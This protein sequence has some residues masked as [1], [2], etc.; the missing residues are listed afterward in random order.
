MPI[1]G[2]PNGK[3]ES[4][5]IGMAASPGIPVFIGNAMKA[6]VLA[7]QTRESGIDRLFFRAD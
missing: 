1:A 2:I 5:A 7:G 6:V 4:S 3:D